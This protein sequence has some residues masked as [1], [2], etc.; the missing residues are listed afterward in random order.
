MGCFDFVHDRTE[1][2]QTLKLLTVLDEYT[3][4]CLEIRVEKHMDSRAV[5]ETLDELMTERGSP[6]YTR[7]D[8]GPEGMAKLLRQWLQEKGIEPVSIEPGSPWENG[9][10][11]S[12]PGRFRDKC[13]NEEV[14]GSR[15]E[16]QAVGDWWRWV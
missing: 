11:E 16:V 14:F 15:A 9:F 12:F 1:H 4:E 2:G 6:R 10:V 13:L 3:R 7:S 8:S 5:L